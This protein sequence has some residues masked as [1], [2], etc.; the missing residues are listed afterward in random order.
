MFTSFGTEKIQN[1]MTMGN[2]T[3][4]GICG[5]RTY[6][7]APNSFMAKGPGDFYSS[8]EYY[9][10][11]AGYS[12]DNLGGYVMYVIQPGGVL[13]SSA[14][15]TC[16]HSARISYVNQWTMGT[17]ASGGNQISDYRRQATYFF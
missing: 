2:V 13:S 10:Y 16:M 17:L 11:G 5:M 15:V 3:L 4:Y 1:L 14:I 12:F 7:P 6:S 8:T 9:G